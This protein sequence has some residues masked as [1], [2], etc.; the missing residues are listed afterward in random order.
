MFRHLAIVL[1]LLFGGLFV[2][3]TPLP[4]KQPCCV[5]GA[6]CCVEKP[7]CCKRVC[8]VPGAICC[9]HSQDCCWM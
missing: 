3:A 2:A 8:C 4:P 6:M 9:R 1:V 7:N 5:P